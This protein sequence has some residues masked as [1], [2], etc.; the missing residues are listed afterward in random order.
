MIWEIASSA[1]SRRTASRQTPSRNDRCYSTSFNSNSHS[2]SSISTV[3][4]WAGKRFVS[5]SSMYSA[6]AFCI[7]AWRSAYFLT[8][9]GVKRSNRPNRSCVTSTCPSQPTPAPMPNRR[10]GDFLRDE[11]RQ[12][13][14]D[15]FQH[16]AEAACFFQQAR[17]FDQ[18]L[19]G[20]GGFALRPKAA[21][22]VD[23][24]RREPEVPHHRDARARN[25]SG[26]L[27]TR[28]RPPSSLTL[29]IPPCC[30]KRPALR[31]ASSTET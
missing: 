17:I 7:S 23:R 6:K 20:T 30:R 3:C 2:L 15:R 24:L 10:D 11:F 12:T 21:Q 18:P 19:G 13:D 29:S 8:N 28:S 31:I 22:L 25:R 27:S 9:F 4:S 16:Q 26:W 5:T 14:R 1:L